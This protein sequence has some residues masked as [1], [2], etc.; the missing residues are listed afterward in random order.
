MKKLALN[1]EELKVET[2]SSGSDGTGPR[3]GTVRARESMSDSMYN[4]S[5]DTM[6]D[7]WGYYGGSDYTFCVSC[8]CNTDRS[9]PCDSAIC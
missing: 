5:C 8:Y 4:Y 1:I 3:R 9:C 2:F 6:C 7:C